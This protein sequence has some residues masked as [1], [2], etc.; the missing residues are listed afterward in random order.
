MNLTDLTLDEIFSRL[1][2][3]AFDYT[4][5]SRK[6]NSL[7]DEDFVSYCCERVLGDFKS[8][9]DYHQF[10]IETSGESFASSTVSD[11]LKSTR[12]LKVIKEL[13]HGLEH[14]V[15]QS[16]DELKVDYLADFDSL[17]E[18]DVY[19]G[20]GHFIQ[21][22]SHTKSYDTK[23]EK[24]RAG[25]LPKLHAAG[26]LYLQSLR[27]GLLKPY[28]PVT[29]GTRKNHEMPVFRNAY[30][31]F[32]ANENKKVIFVLDRAYPDHAWWASRASEGCYFISRSKSN[33]D[34]MPC[35]NLY[36]NYKL[37]INKGVKRYFLAGIGKN[38]VAVR[39]IDYEDPET[40]AQYQFYT[41]L[42]GIE[43]GLI[44][45]LYFKRWTIEKT[46]DVTKNELS[47]KKAWA[48]GENALA[49]QSHTIALIHNIIRLINEIVLESM[50]DDEKKLATKKYDK[51]IEQREKK[52]QAQG[53]QII[54]MLKVIKKKNR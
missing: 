29:D 9:R 7:S 19:A 5:A 50:D 26:T 47:E 51:W 14:I 11:A 38:S 40:G 3:E 52:A 41:S 27:N 20:D 24:R 2:A 31:D 36:V 12:R 10:N 39:F 49:I 46:F 34:L 42:T 4:R 45:W 30:N 32:S 15:S 22:A 13:S 1:I 16:M 23:T 21:H 18:Y 8:G 53:R 28:S 17:A 25:K 37:D 44:A 54:P 43:P 48:T 6:C 33:F 35:G